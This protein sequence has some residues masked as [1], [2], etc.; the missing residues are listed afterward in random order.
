MSLIPSVLMVIKIAQKVITVSVVL[1][2]FLDHRRIRLKP[3]IFQEKCIFLPNFV[4]VSFGLLDSDFWIMHNGPYILIT[5]S[6]S[7][8]YLFLN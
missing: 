5:N 3:Q 2:L 7:C 6:C 8:I 4:Y 1:N